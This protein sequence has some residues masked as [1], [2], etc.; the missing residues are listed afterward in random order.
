M[1]V[2]K[3]STLWPGLLL[4]VLVGLAGT[5]WASLLSH[6]GDPDPGGQILNALQSVRRAVPPSADVT[7]RQQNGS[8]WDS[9]DGRAGTFGWSDL[10]ADVEFRSRKAPRLLVDDADKA[11][12]AAG[13][14][15]ASAQDSPLGPS[16]RWTRTVAGSTQASVILSPATGGTGRTGTFKPSLRHRASGRKAADGCLP[17]WTPRT[18]AS[19]WYR[20]QRAT[21]VAWA[22]RTQNS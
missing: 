9:C 8:T 16:A 18:A 10:T 4:V 6:H 13:W 15:Y 7:L 5:A 20:Q 12:R 17:A 11:L 1:E 22:Q 3:R 19:S 21:A 14:Q 2:M